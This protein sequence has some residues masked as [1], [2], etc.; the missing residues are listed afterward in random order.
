MADATNS[1]AVDLEAED[2]EARLASTDLLNL[3]LIDQEPAPPAVGLRAAQARPSSAGFGSGSG[4]TDVGA[5]WPCGRKVRRGELVADDPQRPDSV[6]SSGTSYRSIHS[7][8]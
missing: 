3:A 4:P 5:I 7:R 1:I 6:R 2:W 8:K